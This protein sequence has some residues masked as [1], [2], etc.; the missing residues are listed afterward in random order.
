M[1]IDATR[2][3]NLMCRDIAIGTESGTLVSIA[4]DEKEK[5]EHGGKIVLDLSSLNEAVSGLQ[6]LPL[7]DDRLL[8]LLSTPS[9][10]Y[11]FSGA[12]DLESVAANYPPAAG[13]T[14]VIHWHRAN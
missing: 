14:A 13:M 9:R 2:S 11:A 7:P 8:L 4:C 3:T 1:F 10:L 12:A 6:Q 5:K